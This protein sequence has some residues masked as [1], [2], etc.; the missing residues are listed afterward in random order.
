ME[1]A[2]LVAEPLVPRIN[3]PWLGR[4]RVT[5]RLNAP[6]TPNCFSDRR[7]A[8]G[9]DRARPA[10]L[11]WRRSVR[12]YRR[13]ST[14]TRLLNRGFAINDVVRQPSASERRR[15]GDRGRR[16]GGCWR[17]RRAWAAVGGG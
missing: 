10:A 11:S 16:G 8:R 9:A 2:R 17:R 1:G 14:V 7:H 15:D 5:T 13:A 12:G 6:E 4:F 3:H